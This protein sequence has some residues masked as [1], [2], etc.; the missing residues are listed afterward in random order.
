MRQKG[1]FLVFLQISFFLILGGGWCKANFVGIN[2]T[3]L[4]GRW[5]SPEQKSSVQAVLD[6]SRGKFVCFGPRVQ[7][8]ASGHEPKLEKAAQSRQIIFVTMKTR[9]VLAADDRSCSKQGVGCQ[10]P[11]Y[12]K[13]HDGTL[14]C[15]LT[16]NAEKHLAI[17]KLKP[18]TQI[19]HCL[20][21][22]L[23]ECHEIYCIIS[24]LLLDKL[25]RPESR[26][27]KKPMPAFFQQ[28]AQL[29]QFCENCNVLC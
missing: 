17:V 19:S 10:Q 29:K 27:Q 2:E 7:L 25:A 20:V 15:E 21:T 23:S 9:R 22:T 14:F 26:L 24:W 18:H 11:G 8:E 13:S 28:I 16:P 4:G 12:H 6:D 1:N 3:A 5:N